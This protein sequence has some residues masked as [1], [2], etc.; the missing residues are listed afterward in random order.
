MKFT[1][2][3]RDLNRKKARAVVTG[4]LDCL[5]VSGDFI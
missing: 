1:D 2:F 4:L 5:G 3:S